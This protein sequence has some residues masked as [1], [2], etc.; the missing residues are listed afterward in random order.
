MNFE[1][2]VFKCSKC[3]SNK[4]AHQKYVKCIT[5][6][7][8][9]ENGHIEY[10]LSIYDEDDYLAVSAGFCCAD[11]AHMIEYCGCHFETE[12]DLL[13]YLTTD[14]DL[15]EHEQQEYEEQLEVQ[16]EAQD[17]QEGEQEYC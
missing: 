14:P 17:E 9:Q 13:D 10:G 12:K 3:G 8:L 11:C 7:K 15:R 2:L 5:P 1:N 6:A 16:I 4:L